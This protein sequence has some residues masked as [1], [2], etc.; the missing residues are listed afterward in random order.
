MDFRPGGKWRYVMHGP[1][2]AEHPV[3]GVFREIVPMERIVVSNEFDEGWQ[4]P[5]PIELPHGTIVVTALFEEEG[6][7]TR[8]TLRIVHDTAEGRKKHEAM[9]VVWGWQSSFDCMDDHLA[10]L[11]DEAKVRELLAGQT[12]ATCAKDVDGLMTAYAPEFVAFDVKLP[13]RTAGAA[14]WRRT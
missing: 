7:K 12:R 11:T 1:D 14:A 4:P 6:A 10:A 2:G 13:F 9:G 3:H 5:Q 8:L